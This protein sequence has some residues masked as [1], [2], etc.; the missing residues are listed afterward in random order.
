MLVRWRRL[1]SS[2]RCWL[3]GEKVC[4]SVGPAARSLRALGAFSSHL[5]RSH[6]AAGVQSA[7]STGD[8]AR[9]ED[10]AASR[11]LRFVL[12]G[13]LREGQERLLDSSRCSKLKTLT[14]DQPEGSCD[15]SLRDSKRLSCWMCR[16][17]SVSGVSGGRSS[18]FCVY[19]AL[20]NPGDVL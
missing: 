20:I 2:S 12:F 9:C 13:S 8:L 15:R 5:Y 17:W 4:P 3:R 11:A 18:C 16:C 19:V 6:T 14:S 7:E 10:S 1:V